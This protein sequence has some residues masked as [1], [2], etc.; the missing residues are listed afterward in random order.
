MKRLLALS[1]LLFILMP[2]LAAAQMSINY[3]GPHP[4]NPAAGG[5]FCSEAGSH[6]HPYDIDQNL[7]SVYRSFNSHWHF[8]GNVYEFGYQGSAYPYYGHHPLPGEF[9]GTYCYLDGSHY[10]Y[11]LPPATYASQ[12]LVH[13]GYYYYN[14]GFPSIYYTYRPTYYQTYHTYR[15]LPQYRHHYTNY[16]TTYTTYG[17]P[18]S[19]SYIHNP[20]S[21]Y[22]YRPS[23]S[24]PRSP[25]VTAYQTTTRTVTTPSAPVYR[26]NNYRSDTSYSRPAETYRRPVTTQPT[27]QR[28]AYTPQATRPAYTPQ[29]TRPAYTPQA[30]QPAHARPAA[31]TTSRTT[32]VRTWRR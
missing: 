4:V 5:G 25:R 32:T 30:T 8:V 13:N 2:S 27:Y 12:Y 17:R 23:P 19:V 26:Y 21:T 6:V 29:A 16:Q 7:A 9:G 22:I 14:G 18:A 24:Y 31:T 20:P 15:Y 1:A 28:P 3:W 10:H 11:F